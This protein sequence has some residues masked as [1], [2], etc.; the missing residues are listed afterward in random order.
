MEL[1]HK[2]MCSCAAQRTQR[3]RE[4]NLGSCK[5]N[6]FILPDLNI[7]VKEGFYS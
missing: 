2:G 1:K 7:L 4:I 6:L 3:I 5:K